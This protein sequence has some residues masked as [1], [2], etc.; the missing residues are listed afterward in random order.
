MEGSNRRVSEANGRFGGARTRAGVYTEHAAVEKHEVRILYRR[1]TTLN[2][3]GF[4]CV[5]GPE[6]LFVARAELKT[7]CRTMVVV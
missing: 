6:R 2:G 1:R 5:E 4:F 3:S 7:Q